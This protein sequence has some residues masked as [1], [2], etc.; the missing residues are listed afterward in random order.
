MKIAIIGASFSGLVAGKKLA[1]AGHDVTLLEQNSTLGGTLATQKNGNGFFDYGIPCISAQTHEFKT[2]IAELESTGL[3]QKWAENFKYYDGTKLYGLNPNFENNDAVHYASKKGIQ[4]IIEYFSR[5]MDVKAPIRVGGLTYIGDNRHK[6]RAWMLNLTDI[7]TFECDA[8]IVATDAVNA[9][10]IMQTTQNKT[11]ARRIAR[12]IDEIDYFPRY[13]LM[14]SVEGEIP[15]W[16]GIEAIK[17]NV[18]WIGNESS[19]SEG[20][21]GTLL[22][23]QSSGEFAELHANTPSQDV[24]RL[25]VQSASKIIGDAISPIESKLHFWNFFKP[26]KVLNDYFM[27]VEIDDAPFALIGDYFNE[28]SLDSAY[29]SGLYLADYWISKFKEKEGMLVAG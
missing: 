4:S 28:Y 12:F 10:A 3:V 19:K 21:Q 7:N 13:S 23:I 24:T 5:W 17:S 16:K 18:S 8:V 25:L 14:V 29:L 2:F 15:D 27:E 9:N 1:E 11:T 26:K 6:K 22:T 20:R